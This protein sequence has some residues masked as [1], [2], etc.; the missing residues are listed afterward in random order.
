MTVRK[1][2]RPFSLKRILAGIFAAYLILVAGFWFLAGEQLHFRESRGNLPMPGMDAGTTELMQGVVVEQEF[3][4]DIQR[5][6]TVSVAFGS[7]YRENHGTITMEL[8]DLTGGS[9]LLSGS[10]NA[11]DVAEGTVLE[12]KEDRPLEESFGVPLLLRIRADS[13]PGEG[14]VPLMNNTA[15]DGFVLSVNGEKTGG[16]LCFAVSGEDYIWLGKNYWL[17]TGLAG[18]ALA[19]LLSVV[20]IRYKKDRHSYFVNALYAMQKYR[21]LIRQ[22]VARDFKIKYKRSLLGV[23][24]SFLNPLMM[25][26]IQY[27]VFSTLFRNDVQNFAVYLL[28]GVVMY[29]FFS[30]SCSLCLQSILGNANLITKVYVPK[31]IY[32]L[33]RTMSSV[34]NLLISLVP[35]ILVCIITGIRFTAPMIL[36]V[37]FLFCLVVF[38]L[39]LG[40]LLAAAM[41]FFRDMQFIWNVLSM[42]WMYATPIF[43]PERILPEGIRMVENFNPLYCFIQSARTCIM[44]GVSPEPFVF[45]KAGL[46]AL[47]MLLIGALVFK[48]QQDKF[49]LYL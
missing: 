2:R 40:M 37:F 42:M 3:R 11:S 47:G 15:P 16:Q 1:K 17:I 44:E 24:W 9:K 36:T 10:Y 26:L 19:L 12:L 20:W 29:N 38:S 13:T 48:K 22:L 43:Y 46:F 27:Y 7:Y 25:M 28:I 41:V 21:F 4:A 49:L 6:R 5:I 30:E 23:L 8:Y 34:I 39:G 45:V 14:A 31:Y 35:L 18:L 32:P 33:T